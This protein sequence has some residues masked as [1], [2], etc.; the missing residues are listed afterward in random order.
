MV[1]Q[2]DVPQALLAA[3]LGGTLE[4]A[5]VQLSYTDTASGGVREL[6]AVLRVAVA[7][8]ASFEPDPLVTATVARFETVAA[9]EQAE[10]LQKKGKSVEAVRT[11]DAVMGKLRITA[12]TVSPQSPV[13][14]Q[15][16]MLVE[17]TSVV[18]KSLTAADVDVSKVSSF[19]LGP[20]SYGC[21][22][23]QLSKRHRR[24]Q[25]GDAGLRSSSAPLFVPA[26]FPADFP[27]CSSPSGV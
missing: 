27:S 12:S 21:I 6:S 23:R 1:A 9:L 13:Q 22:S 18:R 3:A 17:Q 2:L 19:V 14:K 7:P 5:D 10:E 25:R 24:V 20:T 4:V 8:E 26:D 11:L 16:Q 15:I